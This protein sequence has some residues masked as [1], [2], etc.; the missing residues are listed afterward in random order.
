MHFALFRHL[1]R[2]G[3]VFLTDQLLAY[4]GRSWSVSSA[5]ARA[6]SRTSDR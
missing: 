4:S 1:T 5:A 3:D 6:D 2:T